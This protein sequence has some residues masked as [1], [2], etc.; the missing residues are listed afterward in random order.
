MNTELEF[1]YTRWAIWDQSIV[2]MGGTNNATG[3]VF[4]D[5][6]PNDT[7]SLTHKNPSFGY[8]S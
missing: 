8:L 7:G 5:Y 3:N 6:I 4:S 1:N 2:W